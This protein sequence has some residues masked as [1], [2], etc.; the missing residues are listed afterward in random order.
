MR[1]KYITKKVFSVTTIAIMFLMT[2]V[3]FQTSHADGLGSISGVVWTDVNM[4]GQRDAGEPRI[5]GKKVELYIGRNGQTINTFT[6]SNGAYQFTNLWSGDHLLSIIGDPGVLSTTMNAA[7]VDDTV[8]S[9]FDH[10]NWASLV[11]RLSVDQQRLNVDCGWW[12]EPNIT[13]TP[14]PPTPTPTPTPGGGS[15]SGVVWQD[16]NPDGRRDEW[17]NRRSGVWIGLRD[18]ADQYITGTQADEEGNYAFTG[19]SAGTYHLDIGRPASSWFTITDAAGVDETLDSDFSGNVWPNAIVT[20]QEGQQAVLDCG[21]I[22]MLDEVNTFTIYGFIWLDENRNGVWNDE[23]LYREIEVSIYNVDTGTTD[24]VTSH[25][26]RWEYVGR[27]TFDI[28]FPIPDGYFLT[29][30]DAGADDFI[31]SDFSLLPNV[32]PSTATIRVK[33]DEGWYDLNMISVDVGAGIYG[34][35][36]PTPTLAADR[37]PTPTPVDPD[38]PQTGDH[39]EIALMI[40]ALG[41]GAL[42]LIAAL[43]WRRKSKQSM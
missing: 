23:T 33:N 40:L 30:T 9:D 34:L 26:G 37:T 43:F 7:G 39:N 6:D 2:L 28:T 21:F 17:E 18:G 14:A 22:S 5:Q 35:N 31:D 16:I 38:I 27:G 32:S 10:G 15:I 41:A 4:N 25:N 24:T 13:P 20:L 19:L 11:I 42:L 3:P 12:P 29:A 1:R 36:T 8:D